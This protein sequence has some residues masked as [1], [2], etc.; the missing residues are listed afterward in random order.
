MRVVDVLVSY[1]PPPQDTEWLKRHR[2]SVQRWLTKPKGRMQLWFWI[3]VACVLLVVATVARKG[4]E[5]HVG[6]RFHGV[7]LVAVFAWIP[8]LANFVRMRRDAQVNKDVE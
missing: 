7:A 1:T 8:A 2:E 5:G 4:L 6:Y 3:L